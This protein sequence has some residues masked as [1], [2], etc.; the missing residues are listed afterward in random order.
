[1]KLFER[2]WFLIAAVYRGLRIIEVEDISEPRVSRR[3]AL[4]NFKAGNICG[5]E[6]HYSRE[7][8]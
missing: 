1:M 7:Q 6:M 3:K 4:A 5:T 8:W 2:Y